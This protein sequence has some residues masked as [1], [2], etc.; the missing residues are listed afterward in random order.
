MLFTLALAVIGAGEAWADGSH[1][2][3]YGKV[4]VI[5]ASG[6]GTVYVATANNATTGS[7]SAT[8]DCGAS[9]DNDSKTYYFYAKPA[10]GY[11]FAGWGSSDS[12]GP[13]LNSSRLRRLSGLSLI[14]PKNRWRN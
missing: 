6:E 5:K 9:S 7:A 2:T 14:I 13:N 11:Y 4:Q 3:H 8:W 10:D 12:S 1:S